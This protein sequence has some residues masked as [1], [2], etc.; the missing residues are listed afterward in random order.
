M[1]NGFILAQQ[2][3]VDDHGMVILTYTADE[4]L[5]FPGGRPPRTFA[6]AQEMASLASSPWR[7]MPMAATR[8]H[9]V[10]MGMRLNV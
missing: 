6:A 8:A 7:E 2:R 5:H 10:R 3:K 9:A 1:E 4:G